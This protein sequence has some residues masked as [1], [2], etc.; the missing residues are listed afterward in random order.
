MYAYVCSWF[1]R[2][3]QYGLLCMHLC[4]FGH[5]H[6]LSAAFVVLLRYLLLTLVKCNYLSQ[7][8]SMCF[9]R[10]TFYILARL[11]RKKTTY[12]RIVV[13]FSTYIGHDIRSTWWSCVPGYYLDTDLFRCRLDCFRWARLFHA[14]SALCVLQHFLHIRCVWIEIVINFVMCWNVWHTRKVSIE[15]LISMRQRVFKP[16]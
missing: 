9:H 16:L 2:L 6:L 5:K 14:R 8:R 3:K 10:C 13:K 1:N 15:L 4:I 11:R 12:E 7:R